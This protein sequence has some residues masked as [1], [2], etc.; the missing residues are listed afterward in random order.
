MRYSTCDLTGYERFAATRALVVEENAIA[1]IKAVGLTV[2]DG[3]PVAIYLRRAIRTTRM[4]LSL[5]VLRRRSGS[6]HFGRTRLV[7]TSLNAAASNRIQYA[8]RPQPR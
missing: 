3:H 4:E 2:I 1:S 5:F 6:K 7:E 8:G